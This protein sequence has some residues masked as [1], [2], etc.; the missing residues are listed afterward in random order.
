MQQSSLFD[1]AALPDDSL[2]LVLAQLPVSDLQ[3]VTSLV[4][5]AWVFQERA[6]LWYG[7]AR[8]HGIRM[9]R[10]ASRF[11]SRSSSR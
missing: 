2:M 10:Q 11:S 1:L 9:P 7:L 6:A 5:S 4:C 3:R 8:L